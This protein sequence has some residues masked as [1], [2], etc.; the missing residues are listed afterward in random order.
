MTA[1]AILGIIGSLL[2]GAAC[3]SLG[4]YCAWNKIRVD[5][6]EVF[7]ARAKLERE[8]GTSCIIRWV[9]AE[10]ERMKREE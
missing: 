1:N 8:V 5:F 6:P 3:F 9:A 4:Y 10:L 7:E 2:G